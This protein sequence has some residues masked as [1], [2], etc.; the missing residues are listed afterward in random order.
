MDSHNDLIVVSAFGRGNWMAAELA[1]KGLK[2]ILL[3]VSDV[4]GH[5]APEDWEGPFGFF[6]AEWVSKS[7]L[8]RLNEEDYMDQ[9]SDGF[10][11]WLPDGVVDTAGPVSNYRLKKRGIDE[12]QKKYVTQFDS[13]KPEERLKLRQGFSASSFNDNWFVNFAHSFA[14]NRFS[15]NSEAMHYAKPAPL[16]SP[17]SIRRNS[18]RGYE[19]NLKWVE[20]WGAKVLKVK[21]IK[22]ISFNSG[23]IQSLEIQSD[24]SGVLTAGQY[25]W[26]LSGVESLHLSPSVANS[27]FSQ[28]IWPSW[29]WQRYRMKF[30]GADIWQTL[31]PHLVA[32]NDLG[33][34]WTH[35]NFIVMQKSVTASDFDVWMRLPHSQRFHREYLVDKG[36]KAKEF[37]ES[38]LPGVR[39]KLQNH[40]QEYEY[41]E[42]DLG[43]AR[44][45]L[46]DPQT[47]AKYKTGSWINL[48]YDSP[49]VWDLLDW[50][51]AFQS[52]AKIVSE[53]SEW[54]KTR[55]E[56]REREANP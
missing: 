17:H 11:V 6:Q 31:P 10:V 21:D 12:S 25:I 41:D 56:K 14:S 55:D 35:E 22:D 54:K 23:Y 43:P 4:L 5:W 1:S 36:Q 20:S 8:T 7:Q 28:V 37:I 29:Q 48:H 53:I 26:S 33:L 15:Q 50:S 2:T 49:E 34:P 39:V 9:E 51:S 52:Q 47:I 44:Y 40:P 42:K 30:E 24:W 46:Y 18:R 32:I 16:F 27:L 13:L 38:R 45:P 3:D 19:Q